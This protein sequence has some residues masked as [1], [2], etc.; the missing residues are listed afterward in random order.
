M[1]SLYIYQAQC[2]IP[3]FEHHVYF[4]LTGEPKRREL[5]H[6]RA[7]KNGDSTPFH[8]LMRELGSDSF[9]FDAFELPTTDWKEGLA[10]EKK[11]IKHMFA[12]G[13]GLFK[14]L[15]VVHA[16][17]ST[18]VEEIYC[19]QILN[20]LPTSFRVT[21][22]MR[23]FKL[24]MLKPCMNIDTKVTYKS[25]GHAEHLTGE[26]RA[27]IT[28]SCKTGKCTLR[29]N[30]YAFLDID[31]QPILKAGHKNRVGRRQR[32]MHL[33]TMLIVESVDEAARRWGESV[34]TVQSSCAGLYESTLKGNSF[35]YVDD[36]NKPRLHPSHARF[37]KGLRLKSRMAF[38][39]WP[40]ELPWTEANEPAIRAAAKVDDS[41]SAL[42]KKCGIDSVHA[43]AHAAEVC[44]GRRPAVGDYRIAR[45]DK[46]TNRPELTDKHRDFSK[47]RPKSKAVICLDTGAKYESYAAAARAEN[48][49]DE[50]I[51]AC[52]KGELQTTGK[53]RF[54]HLENG[55]PVLTNAHKVRGWRG[56]QQFMIFR[57][58]ARTV[59]VKSRAAAARETGLSLKLL[60]KPNVAE[61]AREFGIVIRPISV[62]V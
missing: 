35:C 17:S 46:E 60:A 44:A 29:G 37:L 28:R 51:A 62:R 21:K 58:G 10:E 5:E 49:N 9:V 42:L 23:L 8:A 50:Q 55:Q 3:G 25:L 4:G 53:K 36:T 30:Y 43:I 54:A 6:W 15:N 52:C 11:L 18:D 39:A 48:L 47:S 56:K 20:S 12:L 1:A 27:A 26:T 32:V 33:A 31:D 7:A 61:V 24:G 45:W 13:D 59:F 16:S 57:P 38:V 41:L 22:E 19:L 2:V 14:T 34:S 40:K